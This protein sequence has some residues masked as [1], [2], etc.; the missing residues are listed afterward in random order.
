MNHDQ[1][2]AL[3]RHNYYSDRRVL[4]SMRRGCWKVVNRG[5]HTAIVALD[6]DWMLD[7]G[8]LSDK[9]WKIVD[10]W[11]ESK[12]P[13]THDFRI[14]KAFVDE[15]VAWKNAQGFAAYSQESIKAR[16]KI[17]QLKKAEWLVHEKLYNK[18]EEEN[19]DYLLK[20]LGIRGH[21]NQKGDI[22]DYCI[23]VA[24]RYVVCDCCEGSGK[25]VNPNID[26]GGLTYDDFYDD[27]DFEEDY[28]SGRHDVMCPTC[29]GLR[30]I[31]VP[32]FPK[33]LQELID[34][35]DRADAERVAEQAAELRMGC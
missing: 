4:A 18:A 16:H 7:D 2:A 24:T 23:E 27:P 9:I 13:F 25:V 8:W 28:F 11:V 14:L 33:W 34:D 12:E 31:A 32:E 15:C 22:F 3:E 35:H 5:R 1:R 20:E 30:V 19:F 17:A 29:D 10:A 6:E 21:T 26:A